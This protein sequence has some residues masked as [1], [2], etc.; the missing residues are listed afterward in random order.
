MKDAPTALVRMLDALIDRLADKLENVSR[1]MEQLSA[2]I[3]HKDMDDRRIPARRLTALLTGSA[4]PRP[5]SRARGCR[6]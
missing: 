6:R 3:F 2:H 4:G 5:C 1:D